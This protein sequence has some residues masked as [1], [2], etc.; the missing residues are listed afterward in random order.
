MASVR[1]VLIGLV[2]LTT[3]WAALHGTAAEPEKG[4]PPREVKTAP[5]KALDLSE[6]VRQPRSE[7]AEVV[8]QFE[9]DRDSLMRAYPV[10][11]SPTRHARLRSF[12]SDWLDALARLDPTPLTPLGRDDRVRLEESIWREL[13]QL[14]SQRRTRVEIA[15]LVPFAAT[16]IELEEARRRM[17]RIDPVRTASTLDALRKQIDRA[18]QEIER[19]PKLTIP[20]WSKEQATAGADAVAS[21][22][23]TLRG[24]FG[25]YDGYDPLL[26]WWAAEPYRGADQ[27]LQ[28]YESAIRAMVKAGHGRP[29]ALV[30]EP[31]LE[32]APEPRL[33]R[34]S[35]VSDAP[36]LAALLARPQS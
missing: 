31:N 20:R 15:E 28:Q 10:P 9:A 16:V 13:R 27:G 24:W 26:S 30:V 25:F 35:G 8:R 33:R 1:R 17:E 19:A 4:P 5:A 36:D 29:A 14:E 18:R 32:R 6:L 34:E 7:L 22:R 3:A 21:L 2:A 23:E 11:G 12:Y